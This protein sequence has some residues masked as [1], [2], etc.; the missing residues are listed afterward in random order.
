MIPRPVAKNPERNTERGISKRF[1]VRG[2]S[3]IMIIGITTTQLISV[4][5]I[6]PTTDVRGNTI[7]GK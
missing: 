4:V 7:L 1:M 6:F 2:K 5:T 3:K